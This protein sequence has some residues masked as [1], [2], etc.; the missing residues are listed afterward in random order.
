MLTKTLGCYQFWYIVCKLGQMTVVLDVFTLHSVFYTQ[1]SLPSVYQKQTRRIVWWIIFLYCSIWQRQKT[2]SKEIALALSFGLYVMFVSVGK[3]ISKVGDETNCF[4]LN[5]N[6]NGWNVFSDV[7][8]YVG[9]A[10]SSSNNLLLLAFTI[11]I[12][13]CSSVM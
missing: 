8:S 11:F 4:S 9:W 1:T 5:I 12:F 2:K 6:N 7:L 13:H 3:C 10:S